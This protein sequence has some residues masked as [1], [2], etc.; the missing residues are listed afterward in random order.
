MLCELGGFL[1]AQ[2]ELCENF[3]GQFDIDVLWK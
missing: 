1:V 2:M 3:K